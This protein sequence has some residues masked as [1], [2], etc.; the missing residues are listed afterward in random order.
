MHLRP[1][2]RATRVR[3]TNKSTVLLLTICALGSIATACSQLIV[4]PLANARTPAAWVG[5]SIDAFVAEATRATVS[6]WYGGTR[7]GWKMDERGNRY[8]VRY[9]G[10]ECALHLDVAENDTINQARRVGTGC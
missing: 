5:K 9:V 1:Q 4:T 10:V 6:T 3:P 7:D 2:F 8:Y